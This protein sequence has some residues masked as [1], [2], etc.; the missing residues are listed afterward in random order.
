MAVTIVDPSGDVLAGQYSDELR[1]QVEALGVELLL[2]TSLREPP[3][4]P[5]GV[6][7]AF[8]VTTESGHAIFADI[9]F[10]ASVP[11]P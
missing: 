2:D 9:W 1:R 6:A 7:R 11:H 4:P 10:A 3:A 5:P 8:E